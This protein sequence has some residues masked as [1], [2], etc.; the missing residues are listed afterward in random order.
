MIKCR[1]L[2]NRK[3]ASSI[4]GEWWSEL[5]ILII[6]AASVRKITGA[7]LAEIRCSHD[8]RAKQRAEISLFNTARFD[9]NRVNS[10][11]SVCTNCNLSVSGE[12]SSKKHIKA[13]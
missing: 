2:D 1:H 4:T 5:P 11:E 6:D 9:S 12:F 7:V 8:L 13:I 10:F 3:E